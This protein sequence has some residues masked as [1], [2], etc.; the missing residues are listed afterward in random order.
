MPV[1]IK[2]SKYNTQVKNKGVK[3]MNKTYKIFGAVAI[4]GLFLLCSMSTG[5]A[6][7]GQS[8]QQQ[9]Q[10]VPGQQQ[11]PDQPYDGQTYAAPSYLNWDP[12]ETLPFPAEWLGIIFKP[13]LICT[14]IQ[15][16]RGQSDASFTCKIRNVG[17]SI[18]GNGP[19]IGNI[20]VRHWYG[21]KVIDSNF[22]VP[23]LLRFVSKK[24]YTTGTVMWNI[25][26][27]AKV[28]CDVGNSID[29]WFGD[30]FRFRARPFLANV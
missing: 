29:E 15:I 26:G 25:G 22:D 14:S 4:I 11:V 10:Q 19:S 20:L 12:D 13:Q 21:L 1:I 28:T 23:L 27:Y 3:K 18:I 8:Q 7:G 5:L 6:T 16:T 24:V 17:N 2:G 30:N 9:Q